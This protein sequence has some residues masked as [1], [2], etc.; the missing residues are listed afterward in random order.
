[1]VAESRKI[2]TKLVDVSIPSCYAI[3]FLNMTLT[4]KL[5]LSSC[6]DISAVEGDDSW[7]DYERCGD[8]SCHAAE[9]SFEFSVENTL[10]CPALALDKP[11]M[12][13]CQVNIIIA[14][15]CNILTI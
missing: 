9:L 2:A 3:R 14:S 10:N 4:F 8:L 15:F 1:M 13:N 12:V 5:N 11:H 6:L 7:E